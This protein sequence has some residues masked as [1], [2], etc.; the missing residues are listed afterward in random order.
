AMVQ[1]KANAN[2]SIATAIIESVGFFVKT[3]KGKIKQQN[4]AL[5][6]EVLGTV[7]L[8]SDTPGHH[9]WEMSKDMV[10]IITLPSTSTSKTYVHSLNAGDVWYFRNHKVNTKKATYNKSPW[11]KLLISGG[12]KTASSGNLRGHAGSLP[13]A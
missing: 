8:T 9:E 11:V 6:T 13:T 12:G 5:N 7:L 3:T 10:T 2:E 4:D 1:S